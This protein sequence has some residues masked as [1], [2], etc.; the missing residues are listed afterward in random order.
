MPETR[1]VGDVQNVGGMFIY[2]D[3]LLIFGVVFLVV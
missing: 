3:S 1:P 2:W